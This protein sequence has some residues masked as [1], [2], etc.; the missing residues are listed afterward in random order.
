MKHRHKKRTVLGSAALGALL[1]RIQTGTFG[2]LLEDWR[3]IFHY[4][5]R[6]KWAVLLYVILGVLSSSLGLVSAVA[7]KYTIDI[8]T[9]YQT[10]RL[11]LMLVLMIGSALFSLALRSIISRVS[12]KI[13][14]VVNNDIQAAVFETVLD[15]D[16]L[17]LSRYA[18]GD[19]LNR[20]NSD[21]STV[22][23]NAVS[24]LPNLLIAFYTFLA[25]FCVI[26]HYDVTMGFLALASA[27]VL[28]LSS[29]FLLRR[30][31][32]HNEAVKE[33]NSTL[34]TFESETFYNLDTIKSFGLMKRY[35]IRLRRWQNK[36][37]RLSLEYNL[38]TIQ[39]EALL[40]LLGLGVQ[41]AVFGYCLYLL[42]SGQIVYGTMTLF[43]S[44]SASLSATF[45]SLVEVVP[46]FLSSAVSARRIREL[47]QLEPE[48]HISA[49]SQ[50]DPL[51]V[52]GFQVCMSGLTFSYG[53]GPVIRQSDFIARPGE[54]VALVGPSGEGKTTMIRLMLGLV[55][56]QHG[57]V[58]LKAHQGF[59]VEM[60]A[61]TRHLF[62]YVPQ[63][64]TLLSGTVAENL[65]MV[66]E[67]ATDEELE[68]VLKLSCAWEFVSQM[69]EG[70][71]SRLGE[72]G[73]GLSEG[74]AQRLAI[75]RALLKDAPVLLLDEATSALDV[76]TERQVLRNIIRQRP[77]K[78]C[79]VTTHRP[80]VLNLCQ[81][82]YRVMDGQ[83]T[84]LS[85]AQSS[86]MVMDF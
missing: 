40:S 21:V 74:Q 12:T 84:Q 4:T 55:R 42:W 26:L 35:G 52:D 86:Q 9:G 49:S 25:T 48:P 79:I 29:R 11:A 81:R 13:S 27:P 19:V 39:T 15:A 30:M 37:K 45:S 16:W 59:E 72:R 83:V 20:F 47:T 23:S 17:S 18:N 28:L 70:L 69:P 7:S 32:T 31:R 76:T 71:Y 51:A 68:E 8:I 2:E 65:R 5:K 38:F 34:M 54:I 57:R 24:W 62:S 67:D 6:Y 33:M 56:P 1:E 58:Y 50:L 85:E 3:W 46:S 53:Q 41:M 44:Q 80:S 77:N 75:A 22:A 64:N 10:S 82:V 36:F 61:E 43:I 78:T 73:R 66:R 14:L 63:G 60:N